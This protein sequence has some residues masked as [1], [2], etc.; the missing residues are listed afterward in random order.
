MKKTIG[1]VFA[2]IFMLSF[3]GC[4]KQPLNG[5]DVSPNPTKTADGNH[6]PENGEESLR[7]EVPVDW[8]DFIKLDGISYRGDW[9]ETEV[10][11]DRIGEKVG[12]VTCG[13]PKVYTDGAGNVSSSEPENGA[14]FLCGIGTEIFSVIG[15]DNVVAAHDDG[16]YYLYVSEEYTAGFD[17]E[18]LYIMVNG[19][20]M[21]YERYQPGTGDLT[22]KTVLDSFEMETEI[23]GTVWEVYST[24]EY[25]DLSYVLVI[26]GTNASWTYKKVEKS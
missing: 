16:K 18:R 12:E 2:F 19:E 21:V 14:S 26:S 24:E 1:I 15:N 23:E 9:R 6:M 7:Y 8:M 5:H 11:A 17:G 4:N 25:P 22:T 20:L 13:V 10:S 3:V